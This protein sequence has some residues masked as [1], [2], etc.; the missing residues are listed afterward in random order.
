[1]TKFTL[2][3]LQKFAALALAAA[4]CLALPGCS[5]PAALDAAPYFSV[6][7]SG[8]NGEGTAMLQLDEAALTDALYKSMGLTATPESTSAE[9]ARVS[10]ALAALSVWATPES[11]L[12]NGDSVQISGEVDT[13]ALAGTNLLLKFTPFASTV[14]GL[15]T[16][17][18][19]D[20]FDNVTVS[21]DG[22]APK[23]T[24][25]LTQKDAVNDPWSWISY[26]ADHNTDL[27]A[28]EVVTITARADAATLENLGYE[29]SRT[30]MSYTVPDY[31]GNYLMDW[32]YLD[33]AGQSTLQTKAALT[34]MTMSTKRPPGMS[35]QTDG[36]AVSLD[37]AG[38]V[39]SNYALD[40][41]YYLASRSGDAPAGGP[42]WYNALIGVY[43]FSVSSGD[44]ESLTAYAAFALPD[45]SM[46]ATGLVFQS[47]DAAYYRTAALDPAALELYPAG[48]SEAYRLSKVDFAL[49]ATLETAA[50]E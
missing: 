18:P 5:A 42:G 47:A 41:V 46:T 4:L 39:F 48:G 26:T 30:T 3:A 24:M 28:G 29:L 34:A 20:P 40:S 12:S 19:L 50:A 10:Q 7:C 38:L 14:E 23:I 32:S 43:S 16:T 21:W 17:R 33:A 15:D 31:L 45:V 1:M 11:A 25:L 13:D 22:Y 8:Y 36:G 49:A 6:A 44:G 27:R 37:S 9:A 35:L 2:R